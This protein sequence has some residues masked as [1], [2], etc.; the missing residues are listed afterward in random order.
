MLTKAPLL[1][2]VALILLATAVGCRGSGSGGGS[3]SGGSPTSPSTPTY[4][5]PTVTSISPTSGPNTGGTRVTITGTGFN[6]G[7]SVIFGGLLPATN[8]AV[9][10]TTSITAT[11]PAH[12][13][14]GPAI[15]VEVINPNGMG[16]GLESA[17]T[18]VDG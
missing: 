7:A 14:T 11:T 6:T 4:V 9:V 16:G 3:S 10:S 18:F 2:S 15:K 1:A 13:G 12:P 5:P 8:V 17:F